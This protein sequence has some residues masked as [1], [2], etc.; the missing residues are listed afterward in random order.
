MT[1]CPSDT[2]RVIEIEIPTAF[3][4]FIDASLMKEIENEGFFARLGK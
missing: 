2:L 3:D 4:D 1:M